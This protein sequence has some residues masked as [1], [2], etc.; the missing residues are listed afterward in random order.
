MGPLVATR[1]EVSLGFETTRELSMT[2]TKT[3]QT[4][5]TYIII[6]IIIKKQSR[7]VLKFKKSVGGGRGGV[8]PGYGQVSSVKQKWVG[9]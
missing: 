7:K 9:R 4:P 5:K 3:S 1:D 6:I 8:E 2:W